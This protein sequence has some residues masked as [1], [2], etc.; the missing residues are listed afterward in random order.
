M[1]DIFQI[2]DF[3]VTAVVAAGI[4][5]YVYVKFF[6]TD[7]P[8]DDDQWNDFVKGMNKS[9]GANAADQSD[10]FHFKVLFGTQSGTAE[11]F[12]NDLTQEAA[13]YE[14]ACEVI[15]MEEFDVEMLEEPEEKFVV[16]M[17][18]TYGEGDPTDNA[19]QFYDMIKDNDYDFSHLKYAVYG[20]GNRQYQY[21][22]SMGKFFHARMQ[23]LGAQ[24]VCEVGLGDDDQ[25]IDEHFAQWKETFWVK[26]SQELLG[27]TVEVKKKAYEP[28][29]SVDWVDISTLS[30]F[31]RGKVERKFQNP[32]PKETVGL[33][34]VTEHYEARVSTKDGSTRHLELD[35]SNV[36]EIKYDTADNC[37]IICRNSYRDA[38]TLCSRLGVKPDDVFKLTPKRSGV[39][40]P[41][42]KFQ[43]PMNVFLWFYDINAAPKSKL[44]KVMAQYAED[45]KEKASVLNLADHSLKDSKEYWTPLRVMEKYPSI[46][47]PFEA[48]LELLPKLQYRLYTIASSSSFQPN[49][50]S[51]CEKLE[52]AKRKDDS[53]FRG[54]CSNYTTKMDVGTQVQILVKKS[55]FK[56]PPAKKASTPVIMIGPGTGIAPFRAFIQER[57]HF[58]NE[59]DY[60]HWRL[61][62]GCRWRDVDY[63][64]KEELEKAKED[65]VL[66][67]LHLAF[68][69]EG[70]KK[71]YVQ[72]LL[73]EHGE[74]LAALMKKRCHIYVCGASAMGKDVRNAFIDILM[75]HGKRKRR[76]QA[77]SELDLMIQTHRYVQELWG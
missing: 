70:D 14:M 77:E 45:P 65:G 29:L 76:E 8:S 72:D 55:T 11:G 16:F 75:K 32:F 57:R 5:Y 71:V 24:P 22:N 2:A 18:A 40:L 30:K 10:F 42:P 3:G 28:G 67:E 36:D 51:I 48:M 58:Q 44:L 12:A 49:S 25:D 34:T 64:Y 1:P 6:K 26:S 35:I 13:A 37:G 21:F 39:K 56:L 33:A 17:V 31:Q 43:T 41:C 53:E 50:I 74:E 62:F 15:D 60:G 68:S 9:D 61:Y 47:M 66:D 52:F 73:R 63:L 20:L 46:N 27:Q 23:E 19:K 69:R 54:V 4:T 7:A 59:R 38:G